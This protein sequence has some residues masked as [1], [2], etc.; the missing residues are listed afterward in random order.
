MSNA[1]APATDRTDLF[2]I[3][4]AA[5]DLLFR[6]ARTPR[7]FSDAPV[8]DDQIAAVYEL[9]KF[10]PTL[11]NTQPLRL[12]VVQTGEARERLMG[13]L[14]DGNKPKTASAPLAVVLAADT[15]FHTTFATVFPHN[16]SAGDAFASDDA[17][18][19]R[20]AFDQAWLQAGYFLIGVRAL[21]LAAG[22]M[23]GFDAPALDAD[24]LAG[25]AWRSFLVVNI[26]HP[27]PNAWLDR[28]P[29]LD[30]AEAVRTI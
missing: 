18:R 16:P 11:M 4:S 6:E 13:H 29:R 30:R 17:L 8:T 27:A 28:L 22:P 19:I 24:L 21:G 23:A 12:V 9:T 10:G 3:D 7:M 15:A 1:S 26:G 25:T 5:Q 20:T 14:A 2:A